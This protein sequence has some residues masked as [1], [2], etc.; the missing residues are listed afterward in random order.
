M[1]STNYLS[2]LKWAHTKSD[3]IC[4]EQTNNNIEVLMVAC[5]CYAYI[6]PSVKCKII[7]VQPNAKHLCYKYHDMSF[8]WCEALV[9]RSSEN[10][11]TTFVSIIL[12]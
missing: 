10:G 1:A 5:R 6:L 3:L 8:L 7:N 2:L 4:L 12:D 11:N 9:K